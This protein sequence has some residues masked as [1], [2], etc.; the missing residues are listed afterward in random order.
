MTSFNPLCGE[1]RLQLVPIM[2]FAVPAT[3]TFFNPLCGEKRLQPGFQPG[4]QTLPASFTC[5]NP[6][7]GEKRLQHAVVCAEH[8][9]PIF[10][11]FNPLCGEKRLQHEDCH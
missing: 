6:L 11:S 9:L 5:F 3:S 1:K 10:E 4:F 8:V 2:W 7:C